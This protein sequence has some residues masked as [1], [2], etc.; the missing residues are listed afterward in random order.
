[1]ALRR[2]FS[3][4]RGNDVLM[5]LFARLQRMTKHEMLVALEHYTT[6][7]LSPVGTS[8]LICLR[9]KK[10]HF[11]MTEKHDSLSLMFLP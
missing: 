3:A 8:S 7:F 6:G 10:V 9:Q 2:L 1:M 5:Q 4:H 11:L